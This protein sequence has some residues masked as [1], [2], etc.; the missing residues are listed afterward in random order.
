MTAMTPLEQALAAY[1]RRAEYRDADDQKRQQLVDDVVAL[2]QLDL[3]SC[4]NI[5]DITG[6]PETLVAELINKRD[7][8]GGRFSAQTLPLIYDLWLEYVQQH[9]VDLGAVRNIVGLGVSPAVLS[10]LTGIPHRSI[11]RWVAT[12]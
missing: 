1:N 4:R 5:E 9:S 11:S 8:R 12:K 2:G 6:V 3:F 10:K 7:K